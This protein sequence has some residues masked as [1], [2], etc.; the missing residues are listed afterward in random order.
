[1]TTLIKRLRYFRQ[2]MGVKQSYMALKTGMSQSN[3]SQIE[4]GK[5]QPSMHQLHQFAD[6]LEISL[7]ELLAENGK[8]QTI[9]NQ[10]FLPNS[11]FFIRL[12]AEKD[13]QISILK[14]HVRSIELLK[15]DIRAI[16]NYLQPE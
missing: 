3:Y 6:I 15:E 1:M 14:D 12:L 10:R 9:P 16:K 5:I 7:T 2:K 4:S 11:E 13:S 8:E